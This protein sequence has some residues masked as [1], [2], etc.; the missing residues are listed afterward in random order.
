MFS[1]AFLLLGNFLSVLFYR[2]GFIE[3]FC[4]Y[5]VATMVR[6]AVTLGAVKVQLPLSLVFKGIL[7][8]KR[9]ES[10][11]PKREVLLVRCVCYS[12]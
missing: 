1:K 10:C 7:Y 2:I 4:N 9:V 6:K 12:T 8:S 5:L 3:D 11:S